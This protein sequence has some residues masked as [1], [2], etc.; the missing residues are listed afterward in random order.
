ME[1]MRFSSPP[2]SVCKRQFLLIAV[3]GLDVKSFVEHDGKD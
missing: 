1:K 3:G 2:G